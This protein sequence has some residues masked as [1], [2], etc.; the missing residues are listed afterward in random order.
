[1]AENRNE[2]TLRVQTLVKRLLIVTSWANVRPNE[3][4]ERAAPF[5]PAQHAHTYMLI[6]LV[7]GVRKP[8]HNN[9]NEFN[10]EFNNFVQKIKEFQLNVCNV[11]L[12]EEDF[13]I[14]IPY[15]FYNDLHI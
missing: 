10:T 12:V 6:R 1:M 2:N 15:E 9:N 4:E 13:D 14:D 3:V 5:M 8:G 7:T 11:N